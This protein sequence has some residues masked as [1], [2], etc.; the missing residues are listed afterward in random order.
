MCEIL[1]FKIQDFLKNFFELNEVKSGLEMY[2]RC[3][4]YTIYIVS[5]NFTALRLRKS[6]LE[7]F[8]LS[9]M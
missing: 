4:E 1:N 5:L 7:L 6:E 8:E 9:E 2:I 3:C